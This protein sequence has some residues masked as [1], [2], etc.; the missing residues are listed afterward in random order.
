[1][2]ETLADLW[3]FMRQHKKFWLAPFITVL[4]LLGLMVIIA[5]YSSVAPFIYTLF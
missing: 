1:M 2:F 4:M 3:G 5:E